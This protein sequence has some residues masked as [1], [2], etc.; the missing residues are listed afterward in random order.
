MPPEL[1]NH[2]SEQ[3]KAFDLLGR[4]EQ[5]AVRAL[6]RKIAAEPE[7]NRAS[8]YARPPP[9]SSLGA[10]PPRGAAERAERHPAV[11]A[12][13]LVSKLVAERKGRDTAESSFF[14]YSDFGGVSPFDLAARIEVWLKLNDAQKAEVAKLPESTGPN[15]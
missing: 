5:D 9:L 15:A 6:D 3:L 13:A 2:L 8:Y 12:F 11:G 4:A 10:E 14:H 7:E 1:R